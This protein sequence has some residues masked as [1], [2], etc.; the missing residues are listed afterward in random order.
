MRLEPLTP[1][2]VDG[3]EI[4]LAY[5]SLLPNLL[6]HRR[7]RAPRTNFVGTFFESVTVRHGGNRVDHV[8]DPFGILVS[9]YTL[10]VH[11]CELKPAVL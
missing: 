3:V 9:I 5:P 4:L 6:E 1:R 10:G 11:I 8:S 2:T 7:I